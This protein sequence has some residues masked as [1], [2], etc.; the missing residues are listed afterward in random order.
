MHQQRV[1]HESIYRFIWKDTQQGG[2]LYQ[3]WHHNGKKYNK[4]K[5]KT[6]G[7]G[8]IPNQVGIESRPSI[9][10]Q[11]S[12]LG[13]WEVDTIIGAKHSGALLSCVERASKVTVLAKRPNKTADAV[14]HACHHITSTGLPIHTLTFDN[15]KEF[16][17]HKEIGKTLKADTFLP[18]C[19]ILGNAG[20]MSIPMDW[21]GNTSQKSAILQNCPTKPCKG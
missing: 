8:L 16:A 11:K 14:V 12:R 7:R 15:G 3:N 13:D 21:F 19:I 10:D 2:L 5:G 6:A 18:D 17:K 4:R 1:S 20:S 9:V